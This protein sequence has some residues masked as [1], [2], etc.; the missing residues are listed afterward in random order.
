MNIYYIHMQS[1]TSAELP[2]EANTGVIVTLAVRSIDEAKTGC[3]THTLPTVALP[4]T[5]A[6]LGLVVCEAVT[7]QST[8]LIAFA[9]CSQEPRLAHAHAALESPLALGA[10]AAVCF[11]RPPAVTR[12]KRLQFHLQ[13]VL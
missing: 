10:L 4:L 12:A 9:L 5:T 11:R 13:T 3:M 6:Y 7:Q 8:F 1:L 2:T